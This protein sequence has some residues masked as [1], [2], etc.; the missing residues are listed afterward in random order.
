MCVRCRR[1]AQKGVI[2]A[3]PNAACECVVTN[4]LIWV[5]VESFLVLR[6]FVVLYH[7]NFYVF[8]VL[9][10][11]YCIPVERKISHT[12]VHRPDVAGLLTA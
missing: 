4:E 6:P 7:S 1:G 3:V 10:P 8:L 9:R 11:L 12:E 2:P 5:S